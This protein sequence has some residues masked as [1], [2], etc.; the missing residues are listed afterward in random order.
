MV[1]KILVFGR[2]EGVDDAPG[3]GAYRHEDA[4]FRGIF[5]DQ[6]AVSGM[7]PCHGRG[8]IGGELA[9]VGQIP[10]VMIKQ[11][12]GTGDD[13]NQGEHKPGQ[14]IEQ[15]FLHSA[16]S[17]VAHLSTEPFPVSILKA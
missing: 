16:C 2:Q 4:L 6:P 12:D 10:P 5:G 14:R 9:M 11:I 8:F 7:H 15:D 1:V 3:H 13:Y 17:T